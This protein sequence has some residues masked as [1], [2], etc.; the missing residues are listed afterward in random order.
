MNKHN[1]Q[2]NLIKELAD[3]HNEAMDRQ[4]ISIVRIPKPKKPKTD[5]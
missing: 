5:D 4:V 1:E 3:L 2:F